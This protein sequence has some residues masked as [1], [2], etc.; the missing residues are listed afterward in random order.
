MNTSIRSLYLFGD[1]FC[2]NKLA[3]LG[4]KM[5]FGG[6]TYG[7]LEVMWRG[8]THPSMVI[9]G[10]LCFA[11]MLAID[12]YLTAVPLILKSALCA[13][14][15]TAVEFG[16]GMLV[17]RLWHMEVWDYSDEWLHLF[18]QICPLYS[19]LWFFISFCILVFLSAGKYIGALMPNGNLP[20][21]RS[22]S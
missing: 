7:L 20:R 13:F 14:G 10:G 1:G 8:Y 16:I 2:R 22:R 4:I 5:L 3:A 15:I 21:L 18:G 9:A 17:N 11:M 12:R 19:C 6:V